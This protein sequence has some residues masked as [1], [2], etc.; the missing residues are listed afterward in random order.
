MSAPRPASPAARAVLATAAVAAPA[1]VLGARAPLLG[2]PIIA[3]MFGIVVAALRPAGSLAPAFSRI[4]R[5]GLQV[6]IVLL[7]STI[8]LGQVA[9][10]GAGSLPVMLGSLATALL[11]AFVVGR[12]LGLAP[13]LRTLIGVGTGIC[14]AS[15]IAA[16]SGVVGASGREVRHAIATIFAFNLAAVIVFPPLGHAFGLSQHAFGLW[17]GT[18]V[19]DVSSVVA[20]A[21]AYGHAAGTQAIIVKL[22]RTTMI[23]PIALCLSALALRQSRAQRGG[24]LSLRRVVPWFLLWFLLACTANTL[25]LLGPAVRDGLSHAGLALTAAALAAVGLA[26]DIGEVRQAGARPV[27]LGAAVW[28][29][30]TVASL[31]LQ[32]A[33]TPL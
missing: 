20:A 5:Y 31:A 28:L 30:V 10:A 7:G 8:S 15:A 19:N 2:A 17:A 23:V 13:R 32:A 29:A 25:G 27:V 1:L 16:I 9:R 4:S 14:G 22:T 6:A 21:F 11:V 18:A 26:T 12:R 33:L 3:L 24:A